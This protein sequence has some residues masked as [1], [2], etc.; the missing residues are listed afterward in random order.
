M[1]AVARTLTKGQC[2]HKNTAPTLPSRGSTTTVAVLAD[3]ACL[4]FSQGA[5]FLMQFKPTA[6]STATMHSA[7]KLASARSTQTKRAMALARGCAC[8]AVQQQ[9]AH[10]MRCPRVVCT[11]QTPRDS[12]LRS[13][14]RSFC[15]LEI[16]TQLG[17]KASVQCRDPPQQAYGMLSGKHITFI[18]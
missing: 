4:H 14:A 16:V 8:M 6:M 5:L 18:A 13:H 3:R 9:A 15:T 12:Y 1:T 17:N 2:A 11:A 7:F 10:V